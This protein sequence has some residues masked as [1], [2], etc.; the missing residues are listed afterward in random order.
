MVVMTL[1]GASDHGADM[2]LWNM[3][4]RHAMFI[5]TIAGVNAE[6]GRWLAGLAS[7]MT[8]VSCQQSLIAATC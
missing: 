3:A 7:T 2:W 5:A 1:H 6:E 4:L 8:A